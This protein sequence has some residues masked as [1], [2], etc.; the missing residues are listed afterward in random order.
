MDKFAHGVTAG[1]TND[2]Q[3]ARMLFDALAAHFK[4]TPATFSRPPTAQ[5]AFDALSAPGAAFG[6]QEFAFLYVSLARAAGLK[7]CHVW[8]DEDQQGMRLLP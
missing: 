6:C 7:A 2:V 1:A 3:K 8:V 4:A 5:E